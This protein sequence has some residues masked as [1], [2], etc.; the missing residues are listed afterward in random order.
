MTLK[1]FARLAKRE[2]TV[3]ERGQIGEILTQLIKTKEAARSAAA[4]K[5][6]NAINAGNMIL[7]ETIVNNQKRDSADLSDLRIARC[8]L[9]GDCWDMPVS[10][11]GVPA[12]AETALA[13][14]TITHVDEI[15]NLGKDR[16]KSI[17]GMTDESFTSIVSA[18]E[19]LEI[20][21]TQ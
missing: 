13:M 18:M 14:R 11:L 15:A 8:I 7:A 6:K 2:T 12:K 5:A 9:T 10:E 16:L 21:S 4:E 3:Q 19:D 1:E 20:W 17:P